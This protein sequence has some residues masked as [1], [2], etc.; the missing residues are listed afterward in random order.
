[1]NEQ[2]V[3][4]PALPYQ[5]DV[6][7]SYVHSSFPKFTSVFFLPIFASLQRSPSAL[8]THSSRTKITP[9][10]KQ[11]K[12]CF[13]FDAVTSICANFIQSY[14]ACYKRFSLSSPHEINYENIKCCIKCLPL[15]CAHAIGDPISFSNCQRYLK[16]CS[17]NC[18]FMG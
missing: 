12:V 16:I 11:R 9:A 8:A 1:M 18:S 7:T 2:N 15:R 14:I 13:E 17:P 5:N 6:A 10:L 3:T 4:C